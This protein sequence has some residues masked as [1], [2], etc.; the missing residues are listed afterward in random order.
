MRAASDA[1]GRNVTIAIGSSAIPSFRALQCVR[2]I[3][4][5]FGGCRLRADRLA[6]RRA[7]QRAQAQLQHDLCGWSTRLPAVRVACNVIQGQDEAIVDIAK[8]DTGV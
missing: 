7:A 1:S 2:R 5:R 3:R 8:A 4:C 6:D